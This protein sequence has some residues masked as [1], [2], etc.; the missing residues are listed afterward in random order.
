MKRKD[1]ISTLPST[2]RRE[3]SGY[4]IYPPCF[5]WSH[6]G[7]RVLSSPDLELGRVTR[8]A[9]APESSRSFPRAFTMWL[10]LL[11]IA[12]RA[13][14]P[15]WHH[16]LSWQLGLRRVVL[17]YPQRCPFSHSQPHWP[18]DKQELIICHYNTIFLCHK[19]ERYRRTREVESSSPR[20]G[21]YSQM[22]LSRG[23]DSRV[24]WYCQQH[25]FTP[26]HSAGSSVKE[27]VLS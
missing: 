9:S 25:V 14:L 13:T 5:L 11:T 26:P 7:G 27:F 23:P 6:R 18:R 17:F 21:S 20:L 15:R 8:D 10:S 19:F 24:L 1:Q 4:E 12:I 3:M 22:L 16:P 2:G